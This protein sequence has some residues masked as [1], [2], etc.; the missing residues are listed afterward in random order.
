MSGLLWKNILLPQ[1]AQ[2]CESRVVF[3]AIFL[4]TCASMFSLC[5]IVSVLKRP[6][7]I[8]FGSPRRCEFYHFS[9]IKLPNMESF[10]VLFH[11]IIFFHLFFFF[12][13]RHMFFVSFFC[14]LVSFFFVCDFCLLVWASFKSQL[15]CYYHRYGLFTNPYDINFKIFPR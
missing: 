10:S 15:N 14:L 13:V 5:S 8:N 2:C 6:F 11:Y 9:T 1:S 3:L 12:S 7:W 4:C